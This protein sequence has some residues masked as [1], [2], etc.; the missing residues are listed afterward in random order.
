MKLSAADRSYLVDQRSIP[1]FFHQPAKLYTTFHCPATIEWV[2]R[3]KNPHQLQDLLLFFDRYGWT[4]K[5]DWIVLGK[6][7]NV[8][9]SDEG[10]ECV[11]DLSDLHA[12]IDVMDETDREIRL[13]VG[14]G[15]PN[16]KLL[17]YLRKKSCKGFGFSFGIPGT[18][19]GG[20]RMNAGTPDG[21]F[22]Q[23]ATCV[24]AFDLHAEPIECPLD[25]SHFVYRDFLLG[26][27]W[28][29]Y[30]AELC[31]PKSTLEEVEAEIEHAKQK[32]SR[33]PLTWPNFG[34]VF[35]NPEGDYAAR[36][37]E[38][39]GLKGSQQGDAQISQMHAN[40][41][42]NLGKATTT[43]AVALIQMAKAT[44]KQK[45]GVELQAEVHGVGY[46]EDF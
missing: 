17:Q 10:F 1:I 5:K 29:M 16:G 23:I 28:V 36:L 2:A 9:I 40:F 32:R 45:F 18:V 35:K 33:Q 38:A 7:S 4:W 39:C 24:R 44:V 42:I 13:C 31:F 3:P 43:Q 46:V 6:G 20:V 41:I 14:A 22:S 27:S 11:V 25:P 37:I 12:T 8:L 30:E 19:G 26:H 21:S 34:S 15:V